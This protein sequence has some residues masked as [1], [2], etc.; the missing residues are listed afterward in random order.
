MFKD[1]M[2]GT[3]PM[4]K[5]DDKFV[6]TS[7]GKLNVSVERFLADKSK[8]KSK[9]SIRH[10][11]RNYHH[12]EMFIRLGLNP[13]ICVKR[14]FV[15]SDNSSQATIRPKFQK[16]T[17]RPKRQFV[18]NSKKRQCV[19]SDNSSQAT[20]RPILKGDNSSQLLKAAICPQ[21]NCQ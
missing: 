6:E 11:I 21:F 20:I 9:V 2:N 4:T 7:F 1:V 5:W 19:P 14:Q 8:E 16:A 10:F 18:P 17:I 13:S 15:P 12:K 3:D